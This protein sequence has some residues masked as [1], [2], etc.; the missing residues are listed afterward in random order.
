VGLINCA[1]YAFLALKGGTI[2]KLLNDIPALIGYGCVAI[3]I[4]RLQ[5]GAVNRF[6]FFTGRISYSLYLIHVLVLQLCLSILSL[7]PILVISLSLV[8]TYLLSVPYQQLMEHNMRG[9][10]ADRKSVGP[11]AQDTRLP[12]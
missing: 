6:F 2:G 9:L 12:G 3:W 4:Y 1:L 5:I 10:A 7:P 8:I 11:A